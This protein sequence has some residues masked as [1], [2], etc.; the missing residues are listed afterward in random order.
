[1]F[2]NTF[3]YDRTKVGEGIKFSVVN[4]SKIECEKK[5][6]DCVVIGTMVVHFR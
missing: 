5:I 4:L 6:H 2:C 3:D 1:M